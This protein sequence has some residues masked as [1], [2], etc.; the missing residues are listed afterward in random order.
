MKNHFLFRL[1]KKI[2]L[3]CSIF[4]LSSCTADKMPCEVPVANG[5]MS[6][7]LRGMSVV[8]ATSPINGTPV[9]KLKDIGVN[10]V[11]ALPYAYY[12]VNNPK[13]DS[14]SV[15]PLLDCPHGPSTKHAVM[16]LIR[17][18]KSEGIKVMVKPQLWAEMEWIGDMEFDSEAKWDQFEVNYTRFVLEWAQIAENMEVDLFCIGTEI[19][20][21]VTYRPN[22]WRSLITQVRQ[23]YDGP[24]TY[25]ANWDDYQAVSFWDALDY[26]GVDAYFPL[27]PDK[28]P[29]V[30]ELISAWQVHE[31]ELSIYAAQYNKPILFTEFGYLS[32]D[33]CAYNTWD[34]EA[35]MSVNQINEQAQANALH[36]LVEVFGTKSWW[37]GGFQ[38]KWY[39][40]A[41]SATCE[42][43]LAKDYTPEGKMA[44]D[45]LKKLYQ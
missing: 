25:A 31:Q 1:L 5:L 42:E 4:G 43:D 9:K 18:S 37:A 22:Y 24:L 23:V 10:W 3:L 45:M 28:T 41:L 13:I 39:A 21:F 2:G 15:C 16:E 35:Q 8:A 12:V 19:A 6:N 34:L 7:K 26:I 32:V 33:A 44:V 36:A 27:I 17:Q 38:W 40:D 20:K 29:P 11:A 30:C 14:V